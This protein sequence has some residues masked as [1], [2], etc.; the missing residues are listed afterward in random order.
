MSDLI[1]RQ[2]VVDAI[3]SITIFESVRELYEY[4]VEHNLQNEWTGGILDAIDMVIEVPAKKSLGGER[5]CG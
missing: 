2:E 3:L 1:S 4:T 5:E